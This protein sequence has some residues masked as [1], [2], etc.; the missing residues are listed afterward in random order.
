MLLLL[1]LTSIEILYLDFRICICVH[2]NSYR[3]DVTFVKL[4]SIEIL[5]LD[6]RICVCV[7]PNSY[8]TD[9]TFARTDLHRELVSDPFQLPFAYFL[10]LRL[11]LFVPEELPSFNIGL[12]KLRFTSLPQDQFLELLQK[13]LVLEPPVLLLGNKLS[14]GH[15]V[16][17]HQPLR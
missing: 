10:L 9:V 6:F 12:R 1:E 15:I 3:T 5:Y 4:T 11:K 2:P 17:M 8:R 7:H 13:G 14:S 16:V